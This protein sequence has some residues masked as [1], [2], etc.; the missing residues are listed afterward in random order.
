MR[1]LMASS[2][3]VLLSLLAGNAW[4]GVVLVSDDFNDNSL[5]TSKWTKSG[6]VVEQ[7]QH[8]TLTER[9]RLITRQEFDPL[10]VGRLHITGTWH[11]VSSTYDADYLEVLTRC[12]G[13]GTGDY[14][15]DDVNGI[16]FRL[17]TGYH[18][19]S[20]TELVNSPVATW[21]EVSCPDISVNLGDTFAFDITDD[22]TNLSFFVQKIGGDGASAALTA[23]CSTHFASNHTVFHNRENG[24]S[25]LDNVVIETAPVPEPSTF[26]LFAAAALGLLTAAW[27]KRRQAA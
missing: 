16:K 10:V 8:V 13:Q 14:M 11:F 21:S 5:D 24:V 22:G 20:I 26:A 25:Y 7:N 2:A 27:R 1:G 19:I 15:N 4:S 17:V 23:A 12:D 6:N 9:G 18:Q 3:V